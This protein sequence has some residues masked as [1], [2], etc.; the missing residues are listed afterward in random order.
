MAR[1]VLGHSI[2]INIPEDAVITG[3]VV[4]V[5]Y[6][7]IT[8]EGHAASGEAWGTSSMPSSQAVGLARLGGIAL[9]RAYAAHL[10][11]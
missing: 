1:E 2:G 11:D 8:D 5:D 6:Q 9:E 4:Y 10:D 3:V 7:R